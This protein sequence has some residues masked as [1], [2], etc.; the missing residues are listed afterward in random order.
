M[1]ANDGAAGAYV[2]DSEYY[3]DLY[4]TLH[5]PVV[6]HLPITYIISNKV[7]S[8]MDYGASDTA[9]I[10]CGTGIEQ[11]S[12]YLA[13]GIARSFYHNGFLPGGDMPGMG[14]KL[15]RLVGY[16]H[17]KYLVVTKD[18]RIDAAFS[19]RISGGYTDENTG[20]RFLILKPGAH[21]AL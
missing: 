8:N 6:Y 2:A 19:D 1:Q 5:N 10:Y 14:E 12:A 21:S 4:Y 13:N 18:V 20:E 9:A 11:R 16:A 7:R 15:S 17:L 3:R